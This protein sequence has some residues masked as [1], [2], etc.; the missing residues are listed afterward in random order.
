M[1]GKINRILSGALKI[2]L[3]TDSQ[4]YQMVVINVLKVLTCM[5]SVLVC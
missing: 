5:R 2:G 4:Q 3:R 1:Q